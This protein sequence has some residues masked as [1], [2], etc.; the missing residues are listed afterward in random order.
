[1]FS[2]WLFGGLRTAFSSLFQKS[3]APNVEERFFV[4]SFPHLASTGVAVGPETLMTVP[5]V[6]ACVNIISGAIA[7]LPLKCFKRSGPDIA[8]IKNATTNLVAVSPSRRY[9]SFVWRRS[10]L[11][12]A[13]LTGNAYSWIR[14]DNSGRP[15][16]LVLLS[17]HTTR[18][19]LF[20]NELFYEYVVPDGP[21]INT[22]R[23]VSSDDII[24]LAWMPEDGIT[25]RSPI[26][27]LREIV[28]LYISNI[29]YTAGVHKNGG[30]LRGY[31]RHPDK[32]TK[33]QIAAVRENFVSGLQGGFPVLENGLTFEKVSLT[34]ADLAFIDTAKLT[35]EE[36][37]RIYG[38]PLHMLN[39]MVQATYSNMEHQTLDFFR[40]TLL[41]WIRLFETE[42]DR[43]LLVGD[44]RHFR[45]VETEFLRADF[46]SRMR[47]Y[48]I[49]I[50]S[51]FMSPD[52]VRALENLPPIPNGMGASY[53]MPS[54]T[55]KVT[56]IPPNQENG[57]E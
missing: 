40:N 44:S 49:A 4:G 26:G 14:R 53:Y 22:K 48:Q 41:P 56:D 21:S 31:L 6:Y 3:Q 35:I 28:G 34:P 43:K 19:F 38:V 17:P 55:F 36:V 46:D 57:N 27:V 16:E 7:S 1:M 25:G 32:L 47:G 11:A 13:L 42:L 24:H 52:E 10:M 37:A 33:E 39:V 5:A 29:S 15:V 12:H 50:T 51:G 18:P 23:T 9:S 54:N 30:R 2:G 8:E 20:K 45:F